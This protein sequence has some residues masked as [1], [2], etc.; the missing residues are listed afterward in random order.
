MALEA[1]EPVVGGAG[2]VLDTS[3]PGIGLSDEAQTPE[4]GKIIEHFRNLMIA[5]VT[6][7]NSELI[8]LPAEICERLLRQSK[9]L[10]CLQ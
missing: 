8:D 5:K 1:A 6:R 4:P 9:L 7:G 10:D 3:E 2:V